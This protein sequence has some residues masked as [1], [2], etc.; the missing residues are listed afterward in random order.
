MPEELCIAIAIF[1]FIIL[2]SFL[3]YPIKVFLSELDIVTSW[4]SLQKVG[5]VKIIS[6]KEID[7]CLKTEVV[8]CLS[9][10]SDRQVSFKRPDA[11]AL[12][13]EGFLFN[14]WFGSNF[15]SNLPR[16]SKV[17]ITMIFLTNGRNIDR[18][19][20]WNQDIKI[21]P[22]MLIH[23]SETSSRTLGLY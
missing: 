4:K 23:E 14:D 6:V 21:T 5:S 20:I 15:E 8:I 1:S 3:A 19:R 2:L 13:K 9:N 7:D 12:D 18:I 10:D 22:E 16:N 11:L 17:R